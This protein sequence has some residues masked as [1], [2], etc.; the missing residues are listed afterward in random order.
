MMA[1]SFDVSNLMKLSRPPGGIRE[2]EER[3]R[4]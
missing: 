2:A 3:R 1:V 4:R